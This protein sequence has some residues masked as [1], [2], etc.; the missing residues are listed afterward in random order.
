VSAPRQNGKTIGV[1]VWSLYKM[2]V[3][4][5]RVLHTAHL[6]AAARKTF[7]RYKAAFTN[8]AFPEL[9]D[10][11]VSLRSANGQEGIWLSNGGSIEFASRTR[12]SGRSYSIDDLV[13]DEAQELTQDQLDALM[14]T[15]RASPSG[16]QQIIYLG[17]PPG[18]N[19]PGEVFAALR[20]KALTGRPRRL[21][22]SEWS[23]DEVGDVSDRARWVATNPALG[24]R[25]SVMGMADDLVRSTPESF[26]RECLGW[27]RPAVASQAVFSKDQWLGLRTA[28]PPAGGLLGWGVDMPPS[29][30]AIS[31]AAALRPAAGPVHLELAEY[32][33]AASG[34]GWAAEW[35]AA[36]WP[37]SVA[38]V[39]DAQ[40]PAAVLIPELEARKVKV[41]VTNAGMFARACGMLHDAVRAGAVTAIAQPPLDRAALAA[42]KR[43]IGA[44]GGWGW[45]RLGEVDVSP[46]VAAT[47]AYYGVMTSRRRPGRRTRV[48]TR[49]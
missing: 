27:W 14:L 13:L 35:L 24:A 33:S 21:A 41:L 39:I 7:N 28:E 6:A 9:R 32:R 43:P 18:P 8:P 17:T 26:A 29:R 12:G 15:M 37:K 42:G 45:Q 3:M 1:E 25:I 30:A 22:W 38:V 36:R 40:S 20:R 2:V 49:R 4:G 48:V 46:L 34:V 16:N 11:V 23:V 19:A 5:R 44:A 47:L 31:V 10:M